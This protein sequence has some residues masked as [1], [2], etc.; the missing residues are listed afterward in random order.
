MTINYSLSLLIINN[1]VEKKPRKNENNILGTSLGTSLNSGNLKPSFQSIPKSFILFEQVKNSY[2]I[3][4]SQ[5]NME[6]K[7][8]AL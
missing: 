4:K 5:K 1:E 7:E 8:W 6:K 2:N 3:K